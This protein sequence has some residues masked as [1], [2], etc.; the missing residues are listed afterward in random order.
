MAFFDELKGKAEGLKDKA[1]TVAEDGAEKLRGAVGGVGGFVDEKT[2]G[3]Y[4]EQV[5][6]LQES[7]HH[8]LDKAAGNDSNPPT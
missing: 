4:S 6:H 3:R 1:A 2:G 5:E 8:L 7:A